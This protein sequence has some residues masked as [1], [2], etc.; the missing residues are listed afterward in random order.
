MEFDQL[1]FQ[2]IY[3]FFSKKTENANQ[4]FKVELNTIS[5]K[6]TIL[7][8]A[9]TGA[10]INILASEREGGWQ[11]NSFYLPKSVSLYNQNELNIN[12]YIFR[13]FYLQTQKKLNLNWPSEKI[14]SIVESQKE[15][16]RQSPKILKSL[17]EEFPLIEPIYAELK[18]NFPAEPVKNGKEP[19]QDFSWLFGRWMKNISNFDNEDKLKNLNKDAARTESI[20]PKTVIQAQKADEVEIVHVDKKAQEDYMLTNNFEKID[21]VDEFDGVWRDFDGDDSLE[22]DL[23]ALQ[24]YNL[25]HMVRVDDPVHSVYQADF[26]NNASVA[27]SVA[28][29]DKNYHLVYPEWDYKKRQYDE[30]YCKVYPKK[31]TNIDN[32]YFLKTIEQ[33][34]ALLI[35]LKK[36][37]AQLNN[38]WEQS[39]RQ[40]VGD[41]I[42][43]DAATD[44]FTDIKAHRTP[45]ERIYTKKRK[46]AK[47][48]S[49]LFLLDLSLSSDAYAK[50]NR[51][52]DV[53]KQISILFGEVL[54][55]YAID[56][57]IDGFYSKTRNNT[58]YITLKAFNEPWQKARTKIGGA[59]ATGYT[60]IGPAIRHATS[61]LEKNHHR[62]RWLI[63]LSD[64]KPNDYDKY[65]GK[66]GV[67]DIKQSLREMRVKG[68]NNFAF[69]IE[70]Q[71]KY[72]LPQ[73]FGENHYNILTSPVE[74][75][76]SLTKLYDRI[77]HS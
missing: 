26:V 15:A 45:D 56:F 3:N 25:K 66:H 62:K 72:Y 47:E 53:E 41:S 7:G 28:L 58:S 31:L 22:E 4:A 5:P 40:V 38:K 12:L 42:D 23:E 75:L 39:R 68:I 43:I 50:G 13:L 51:I 55:E 10:P 27:E 14:S 19:K 29:E 63:L 20:N 67:E 34:R 69:A 30:D 18:K 71:A 54:N 33:N 59:E 37:F 6:L 49:L 70:E 2:K 21:T 57:Q 52:I 24:E 11:G 16:E 32:K 65:E 61:I 36:T 44:L 76:N 17:F 9:I 77:E 35:Q 46:E 60:R 48:L 73:M 74:L 64:G 1:L 8:R